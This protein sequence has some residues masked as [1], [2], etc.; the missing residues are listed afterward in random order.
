[1]NIMP[2]VQE[3]NANGVA[4]AQTASGGDDSVF[5]LLLRRTVAHPMTSPARLNADENG[6]ASAKE[7]SARATAP[8]TAESAYGVGAPP[9]LA[10]SAP[11]PRWPG[12]DSAGIDTMAIA[13][14][15]ERTTARPRPELAEQEPQIPVAMPAGVPDPTSGLLPRAIAGTVPAAVAKQTA[16][17]TATFKTDLLSSAAALPASADAPTPLPPAMTVRM[18]FRPQQIT[19]STT[20]DGT[21]IPDRFAEQDRKGHSTAPGGYSQSVPVAKT[22]TCV[23][24]DAVPQRTETGE[25][26]LPVDSQPP[27]PERPLPKR[28]E[29]SPARQWETPSA[30]DEVSLDV[31]PATTPRRPQSIV[32][33]PAGSALVSDVHATK[34]AGE[35]A[36]DTDTSVDAAKPE[37]PTQSAPPRDELAARGLGGPA[38]REMRP[39]VHEFAA[40]AREQVV[41][42]ILRGVTSGS[43]RLSVMLNPPELGRIDVRL[44]FSHDGRVAAKVTAD[45]Q[46]TLDLLQ[47]DSRALARALQDAGLQAEDSNLSFDL[48]R[49]GWDGPGHGERGFQPRQLVE[50]G[51]VADESSTGGRTGEPPTRTSALGLVNIEV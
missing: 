16:N 43:E 46:Q 8:P 31:G 19:A 45:N 29:T 1:M 51:H 36:F 44:E 25:R 34:A 35:A 30:R 14:S 3:T 20:P 11:A 7:D 38:G 39:A 5:A 49:H 4:D 21:A 48:R 28:V 33:G 27:S 37:A 17:M 26:D 18:A 42:Q 15:I 22:K 40:A 50:N 13:P 41:V 2:L 24:G 23:P 32:A 6:L 47:R 9:V 12:G 10:D